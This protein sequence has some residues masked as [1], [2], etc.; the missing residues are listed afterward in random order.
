[1]A[2]KWLKLEGVSV[3]P[4]T[5]EQA[6]RQALTGEW[7]SAEREAPY[8]LRLQLAELSNFR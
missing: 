4:S 6:I 7:R 2:I 5:V 1:M 3:L 8:V